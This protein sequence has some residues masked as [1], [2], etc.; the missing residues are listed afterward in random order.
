[1][2]AFGCRM[3]GVK[4][5]WSTWLINSEVQEPACS[6]RSLLLLHD[7]HYN[8]STMLLLGHHEDFSVTHINSDSALL[9][10]WLIGFC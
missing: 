10:D 2:S 4:D 6:Y 1:M 9:A 3:K 7:S 8:G 5:Y